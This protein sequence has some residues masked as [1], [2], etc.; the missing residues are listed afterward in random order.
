MDASMVM[1]KPAPQ[2]TTPSNSST[3]DAREAGDDFAAHLPT[4]ETTAPPK[5]RGE[6]RTRAAQEEGVTDSSAATAST[7]T[8][9]DA[10][11]ALVIPTAPAIVRP[12]NSIVTI[13]LSALIADAAAPA[14]VAAT[15]TAQPQ[16]T[17]AT[18]QAAAPAT[19]QP[20]QAAAS[21]EAAPERAA[22]APQQP[23]QNAVQAQPAKA[24]TPL[25]TIALPTTTPPVEAR[26]APRLRAERGEL[27]DQQSADARPAAS[28]TA[29]PAA[30]A[31]TTAPGVQMASAVQPAAAQSSAATTTAATETPAI[32][33]AM[34]AEH[35]A[36]SVNEATATHAGHRATTPAALVAQQIIRRF[37]GRSTSID[38]RLDPPE[39]GRV[40]VSLE[41]GAD[42]KVTAV[43]AA[44]NPATLSD[45]VRSSRE[46]ERALQEAGLELDAGGL[47]FDLAER[48]DNEAAESSPGK[49]AGRSGSNGGA[50][51]STPAPVSRPFGLEA[52][53]GARIDVMA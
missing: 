4:E 8:T 40:K 39:L 21:G 11:I 17:G 26:T 52:W 3:S 13:D 35:R 7:E 20:Q 1:S 2:P 43:V 50:E 16:P 36:H 9:V 42:N 23:P 12:Q 31:R 48:G 49:S 46:L 37:E 6:T 53:R 25:E 38:V 45:L 47:S 24:P 15:P 29:P 34:P 30:A 51:T 22:Q 33:E 10:N 41:V 14:P 18:P 44:E 19:P 27:A 5:Q 32:A 28:V